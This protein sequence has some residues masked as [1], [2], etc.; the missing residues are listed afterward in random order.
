MKFQAIDP[1]ELEKVINWDDSSPVDASCADL[2]ESYYV[3][4]TKDYLTLSYFHWDKSLG[5]Y[6]QPRPGS[7][8]PVILLHEVVELYQIID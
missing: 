3:I 8:R 6:F 1:S 5:I 7:G 4:K 2:L